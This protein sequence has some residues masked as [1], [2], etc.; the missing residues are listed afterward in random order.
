MTARDGEFGLARTVPLH[1]CEAGLE[2]AY[3]KD[4]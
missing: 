1:D 3:L 2:G 4:P